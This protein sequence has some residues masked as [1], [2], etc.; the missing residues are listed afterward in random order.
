M[1]LSKIVNGTRVLLN[2]ER[3]FYLNKPLSAAL[4]LT[5][6]CN[7]KCKMCQIWSNNDSKEPELDFNQIK[8]IIEQLSGMKVPVINLFGGEVLL[9]KDILQI[10]GFIKQK[11]I[12]C[13]LT[14]NGTIMNEDI[15]RALVSQKVD[16]LVISVDAPNERHDEIRGITGALEKIKQ[17]L[18]LINSFKESLHSR[19]PSIT[20]NTTVSKLNLDSLQD[21]LGFS[22]FL[23]ADSLVFTYVYE[24]KKETVDSTDKSF[25]SKITADDIFTCQGSSILIQEDN[26]IAELKK[27]ISIMKKLSNHTGVSAKAGIGMYLSKSARQKGAFPISKCY[28]I[29]NRIMIDPLGNVFACTPLKNYIFGNVKNERL[30]DIWGSLKASDFRNRIEK[31]MLPICQYCGCHFDR[32][33]PSLK[34]LSWFVN[35]KH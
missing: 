29:H 25:G 35:E 31:N 9:R 12:F 32:N 26:Q 16:H 2:R 13:D 8:D 10:T 19:F 33:A 28:V 20:I 24:T 18:K 3:S 14:T 30:K 4:N 15:A 5:F 23:K 21:M 11:G 1:M 22:E 6:R 7:L 27:K 34:F 17:A